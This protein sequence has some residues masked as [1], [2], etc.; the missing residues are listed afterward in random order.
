ML[1]SI[2]TC[3]G[4]P[5]ELWLFNCH[6]RRHITATFVIRY[7]PRTA[8]YLANKLK[9]DN[10]LTITCPVHLA[11]ECATPRMARPRYT[12]LPPL[13]QW[14]SCPSYMTIN[15]HCSCSETELEENS[16]SHSDFLPNKNADSH[17]DAAEL[18]CISL[19]H[20]SSSN[21][22]ESQGVELGVPT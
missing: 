19:Q 22:T 16:E 13:Y 4:P 12:N 11:P 20:A 7:P 5:R 10:F 2:L 15:K 17:H 18:A 14:M 1:A 3:R 8:Y 9:L 6:R 21:K